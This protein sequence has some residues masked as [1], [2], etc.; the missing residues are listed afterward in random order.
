MNVQWRDG[1]EIIQSGKIG[2]E[3]TQQEPRMQQ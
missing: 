3:T 1:G 2:V